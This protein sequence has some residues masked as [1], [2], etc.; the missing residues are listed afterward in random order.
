MGRTCPSPCSCL[1]A[2]SEGHVDRG[3]WKRAWASACLI[4]PGLATGALG[5]VQEHHCMEAASRQGAG[6]AETLDRDAVGEGKWSLWHLSLT[7]GL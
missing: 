3:L 7:F 1:E 5:T 6:A 4:P 2:C